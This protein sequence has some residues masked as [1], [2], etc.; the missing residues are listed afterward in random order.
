[1]TILI[2][3]SMQIILVKFNK[4][5]KKGEVKMAKD[6]YNKNMAQLSVEELKSL[7]SR[8]GKRKVMAQNELVKRGYLL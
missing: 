6:K 2:L 3:G 5:Y 1:M 8:G 7:V 4:N